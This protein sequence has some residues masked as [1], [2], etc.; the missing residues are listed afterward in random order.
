[1]NL[2]RGI[3]LLKQNPEGTIAILDILLKI[4]EGASL[5]QQVDF[6]NRFVLRKGK[7]E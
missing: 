4:W 5:G 1:M 3:E 6:L 2:E 7:T